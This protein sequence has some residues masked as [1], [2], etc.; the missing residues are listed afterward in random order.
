MKNP[1]YAALRVHRGVV[2]GPGD[3][4]GIVEEADHRALI[5]FL[6][7]PARAGNTSFERKY[8]GSGVCKCG[9]CGQRMGTHTDA[10]KRRSYKCPQ[11]HVRR[12]AI[13]LDELVEH[14]ILGRLSLPDAG[15]VLDTSDDDGPALQIQRDGLQGRLAE[16]AGMFAAGDIEGQQLKRGSADLRVQIKA[17]DER[18][19]AVRR[20]N[21]LVDLVLA[22]EGLSE[23]WSAASPDIKGKVIDSLVSV[24][25][26]PSPKGLRRFDPEF[27]QIVWKA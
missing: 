22:R 18:L 26:L 19:A 11:N 8:M 10:A 15:L 2:V 7:D 13:A 16:L 12:Q 3:W 4:Q 1:R 24:V 25:V 27:V 21:P 14:V 23:A 5:A 17:I 9:V 20:T 6:D